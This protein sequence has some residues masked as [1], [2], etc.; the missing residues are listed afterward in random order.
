[1]TRGE[2]HLRVAVVGSGFGGLA[3]A[4]RLKQAGVEDLAV[5]EKSTDVGGVWRANT[6]PG[7]AC[8]VPSHLYSLSFAPKSD[9]SRRFAP[10]AE[11]HQYLRDVARDFDV[12]RHIRFGTEV[13]A[14]AFDEA[15]GTWRLTLTGGAEHE[16][17]VVI[18]ATGQ[19][20]RPSRPDVPGLDT[21]RGTVFHSAEWDHGHDMTGRRV[22]VLGT[23]ASAIQFVPAV[24]PDTARLTV[25][26]RSAP[27]VLP[28]RDR[29]YRRTAKAAFDRL[30][31]LLR[32]SRAANY[33]NNELRSLGFNTEPRLF[34]GYLARYRRHLRA[35]VPDPELRA[36]VTPTDP[37]GCKRILISND[38]YPA[39]RLPQVEVVTEPVAVVR[40][41]SVVAADGTEREVDTIVLGTGFAAT[42]LL[43]PMQVTG[44]GGRNLHKQWTDGASA[45][46]GTV[47][48]GFPNFFVLYGPNTNLGH[49]SIVV[50]IE[51]QVGWVVQA[52]RVLHR[53]AAR[54]MDVR[55]DVAAA[56]DAWVQ[57][58]TRGTVFAGG[59][60]S[61]YLTPDGR[62]TQNWPA[63]TLTFRRRLRRLRL[64]EFELHDAPARPDAAPA[65]SD[66]PG[67]PVALP[68]A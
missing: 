50:M 24:A 40:P 35:A 33:L 66:P 43:V 58:R 16:A 28:K 15:A 65:P 9:W 63:S 49:N 21:F 31:G 8:D 3:A 4:V 29:A 64:E 62:N 2:R 6:Y 68:N 56:F 41:H 46:L 53:G 60:T 22:A 7:A 47:V 5:F 51:A 1:M 25:F 55:P 32:L 20:S 42:D 54:W 19:L 23:G 37:F 26:Q 17:D 36:K 14:A 52:V 45:Y 13:L 18:A 30:P 12:L 44:R 57:R 11:I 48:P 27:Y 34:A 39:L 61:W 67:G 38:W 59:C 10:Q